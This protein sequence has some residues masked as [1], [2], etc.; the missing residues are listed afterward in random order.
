[1]LLTHSA[2]SPRLR[3]LIMDNWKEG[4][5]VTAEELMQIGF[6]QRKEDD[7]SRR[8][9]A[10]SFHEAVMKAQYT[11][12]KEVDQIER[13]WHIQPDVVSKGD[14]EDSKPTGGRPDL[15]SSVKDRSRKL[16]SDLREGRESQTTQSSMSTSLSRMFRGMSE[17][18]NH[19][20]TGEAQDY[21]DDIYTSRNVIQQ[22]FK[23]LDK[24]IAETRRVDI[25]ATR[26]ILAYMRPWN[27]Y[28]RMLTSWSTMLD[29]DLWLPSHMVLQKSS[30]ANQDK[31]FV[32]RKVAWMQLLKSRILLMNR[33]PVNTVLY[34]ILLACFQPVLVG[35]LLYG[36][37]MHN[38]FWDVNLFY[39][40][41]RSAVQLLLVGAWYLFACVQAASLREMQSVPASTE[42]YVKACREPLGAQ[43]TWAY[44]TLDFYQSMTASVYSDM[45]TSWFFLS[46]LDAR[47]SDVAVKLLRATQVLHAAILGLSFIDCCFFASQG[48]VPPWIGL[49]VNVGSMFNMTTYRNRILLFVTIAETFGVCILYVLLAEF[50]PTVYEAS[51][52]SEVSNVACTL[53]N[54]WVVGFIRIT[55]N[56]LIR[57]NCY[58][59]Y[60]LFVNPHLLMIDALTPFDA[61]QLEG[62]TTSK[63]PSSSQ[64][65]TVVDDAML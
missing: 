12:Y 39:A 15:L 2:N 25:F 64:C 9:V 19:A 8:S 48:R 1:M 21:N 29:V 20:N 43:R 36:D 32:I 18:S 51:T 65:L 35:M 33:V 46:G 3:R 54:C 16:R 60:L 7:V 26:P 34:Q 47:D 17:T 40:G 37:K 55:I 4:K 28:A 23:F 38:S 56:A 24:Y 53:A 22:A 61:P 10:S 42:A 52:T 49:I 59:L 44:F 63:S 58:M 27:K 45:D 6:L 14:D 11:Y 30:K 50:M 5:D 31:K 41:A 62:S 13:F 57:R